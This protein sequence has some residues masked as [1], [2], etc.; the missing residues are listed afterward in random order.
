MSGDA[1][2]PRSRRAVLSAAAGAAVATVVSTIHQPATVHAGVDGDVVLGAH[3]LSTSD[4]VIEAEWG[5]A[6]TALSLVAPSEIPAL[7]VR[8]K[9]QFSRS[10]RA[11]IR[12]GRSFV[13]IDFTY[14][15]GDVYGLGGTPLCFANVMSYRPG[16]FVTNV[17][18]NYP[19]S[20]KLRIY[21]N[22]AVSAN[23]YVAWFVLS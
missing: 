9:V 14:Y 4:T 6:A 22:R 5:S 3:N 1:S 8:G 21:I 16:V 13:D 17:R 12:K 2:V 11:T 7:K 23:T 18:P 15:S 10:G 19:V 20:G